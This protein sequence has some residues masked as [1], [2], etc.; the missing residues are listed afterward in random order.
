MVSTY[1]VSHVGV[2]AVDRATSCAPACSPPVKKNSAGLLREQSDR[3]QDLARTLVPLSVSEI[4]RLFW[5]L[6]WPHSSAWSVFWPGPRGAVGTKGSLNIG[7]INDAQL[8]NY[9][10]STSPRS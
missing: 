10:C 6:C 5:G 7:T 8:H 4:R 2:C 1:H 3:L 9:N